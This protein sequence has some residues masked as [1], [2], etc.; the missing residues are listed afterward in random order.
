ML[1]EMKLAQR[2]DLYLPGSSDF[3][4][5]AK[6]EN[7]V[8][9]ES[10]RFV[11]YLVPAINVPAGNPKNIRSLEDLARPRNRFA[12]D[13]RRSTFR[14]GGHLLEITLHETT[15][16]LPLLVANDDDE[17]SAAYQVGGRLVVEIPPE[18][19]LVGVG[20]IADSSVRAGGDG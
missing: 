11:A 6:R 8:L 15:A 12:E 4:E 16:D 14:A 18:R 2:G 1:S 19:V 10:E 13:V 17:Q 9:S 5:I 7:L 3:M 20:G